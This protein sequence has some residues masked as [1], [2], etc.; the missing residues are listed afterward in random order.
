MGLKTLHPPVDP[1]PGFALLSISH[2]DGWS[3]ETGFECVANL[4][5]WS[6][7]KNGYF[8]KR[9]IEFEADIVGC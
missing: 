2:L 6:G 4:L 5:F 7:T 3:S 8:P 9:G 1:S